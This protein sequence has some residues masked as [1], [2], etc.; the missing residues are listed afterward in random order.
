MSEALS[1]RSATPEDA[2]A[3][4]R[5]TR[6]AHA[7]WVPI[8]GRE[9]KPMTADYAEAV[10]KHRIDLLYLDGRLAALIETRGKFP[11]RYRTQAALRQTAVSIG[12]SASAP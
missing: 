3:I 8:A 10:Q 9:P 6:Q 11:G 4:L 7:K 1:M 5:L 2:D 12:H